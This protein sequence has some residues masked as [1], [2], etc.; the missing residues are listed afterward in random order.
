MKITIITAVYNARDTIAEALCSILNQGH[1]STELV[2]VD[3]G[4]TDGT[5]EVIEQYSNEIDIKICESDDGLY[6]ALNKGLRHASGDV[7]GFLHADDIYYDTQ[8][9]ERVAH[10]FQDPKVDAVYGDLVYVKRESL[11]AVVRYWR[12]GKFEEKKI[13][14]GWMPPHTTLFIRRNLYERLGYFDISYKISADYDFIL[15][16]LS[17]RD[18]FLVYIPDVFVKMRL[19]GLSNGSIK[20]IVIKTKEDY[21]I[22]RKN[23]L[24]GIYT[25]FFKNVVKI[26]QFFWSKI[27]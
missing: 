20:N 18:V 14:L 4:S 25:L 17:L 21:S 19:G 2:V 23:K 11:G 7:I 6:D 3:G 1:L 9:L 8:V 16:L 27:P 5:L 15:R 22:I 12:S 10:A 13:V 24:N 26:R